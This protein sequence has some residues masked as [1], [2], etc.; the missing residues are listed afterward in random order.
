MM[1]TRR[2]ATLAALALLAFALP[3]AS[4]QQGPPPGYTDPVV[5][6]QAYATGQAEQ[7]QADPIGYASGKATPENA[8]AEA[9]HAAWLACWTAYEAGQMALDPACSRFFVAPGVVD[10][11]AEAKAELTETLNA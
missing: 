2:L 10:A 11:P 1:L 8:S 3:L 9:E 6:A 4:A 5:Y 7:A